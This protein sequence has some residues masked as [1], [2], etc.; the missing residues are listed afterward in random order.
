M[1][2]SKE[3]KISKYK[4]LVLFYNKKINLT[5]ITDSKMFDVKHIEDSLLPSKVIDFNNKKVM[6]IGTGAGFPG[7]ILAINYP[8]STFY[9]VEPILKRCKFLEIV[10]NELNL[11]NVIIVNKRAEDLK[12]DKEFYNFDLIVSRAVS[13][14]RI[15]LELSIPF[16][17]IK[18]ILIAYK[19]KDVQEEIDLS[20]NALKTLNS[21]IE[22]IQHDY[23]SIKEYERNNLIIMKDN[24][25]DSKYPRRFNE[26]K[27]KPL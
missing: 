21:H 26:I 20:T 13:D 14:L 27:K 10:K 8:S 4:E 23:L 11:D 9:L 12:N 16:L 3:E 7:I 24:E 6:D 22:K 1:I 15:L 5:S 2:L 19:G 17:K 25:V 18:G